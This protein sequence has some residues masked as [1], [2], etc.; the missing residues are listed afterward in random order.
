MQEKRGCWKSWHISTW[1]LCPETALKSWIIKIIIQFALD[2]WLWAYCSYTESV[3]LSIMSWICKY[4]NNVLNIV[5]FHLEMKLHRFCSLSGDDGMLIR[6][7]QKNLNQGRNNWWEMRRPSWPRN[8]VS[9]SASVCCYQVNGI[10][11]SWR[12]NKREGKSKSR[13]REDVNLD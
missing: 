11:G 1:L 4:R 2:V 12:Q 8:K 3:T 6:A 7:R 10:P 13:G 5:C 9:S